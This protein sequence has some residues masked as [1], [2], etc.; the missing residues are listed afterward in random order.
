MTIYVGYK[1]FFGIKIQHNMTIYVGFIIFLFGSHKE[2]L[3]LIKTVTYF[4]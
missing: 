4:I 3:S 2:K 1:L